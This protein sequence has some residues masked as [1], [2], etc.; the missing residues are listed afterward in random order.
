MHLLVDLAS[1]REIGGL[2]TEFEEGTNV[3]HCDASPIRQGV[4][5]QQPLI[6]QLNGTSG[7]KLSEEGDH[8]E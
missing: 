1:E 8:I 7:R 2:K 4:I 3:L 5:I 6:G